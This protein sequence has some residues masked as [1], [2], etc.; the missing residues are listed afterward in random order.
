[1][2]DIAKELTAPSSLLK[3]RFIRREA[4][5]RWE[6]I[7]EFIVLTEQRYYKSIVNYARKMC[8]CYSPIRKNI[9]TT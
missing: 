1:M 4:G 8:K 6:R 9:Y 3:D 7:N 5:K 2:V